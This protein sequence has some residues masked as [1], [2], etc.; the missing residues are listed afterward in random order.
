MSRALRRRVPLVTGVLSAV[1]LALVIGAVGGLIPARVLPRAPDW[2]LAAIPHLNAAI[3]ATAILVILVGLRWIRAGRVGR[4]RRAMLTAL[5]LFG[6]FLVLYLYRIVLHGTTSFGGPDPIYRYVYLPVLGIHMLLAI[7]C[8]PL[9]YYV[10]LLA[11]TR[12]IAAIRESPHPRI[13]RIA[14]SLW[15]TSF[16]LGIVVYVLLYWFY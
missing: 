16:A 12:P 4:H 14:V 2:V 10:G 1:S 5:A 13:G 8:I 7:V 15:L 9:L 3:S 11:A 6:T